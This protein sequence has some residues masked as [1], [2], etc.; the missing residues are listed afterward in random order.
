VGQIPLIIEPDVDEPDFASVMVDA[1]VAGRP[2]RLMLD[3]GAGQTNLDAD[4]YTRGL[5]AVGEDS[6]AGVF[7]TQVIYPVVTVADLAVGPLRLASLDVR[8]GENVKAEHAVSG[9]L[10]LDVL[11]RY[12]CHFRLDAGILDVDPSPGAELENELLMDRR[13]HVFVEVHWPGI[14]GR[15]LWDTGSGPTIVNHAFWIG[16]PELFEQIGVSEGLDASG[17]RAETPLLLIA[18][19][20]IGQRT[21]GRHKAVAVDL[22]HVN[23]TS[24]YPMDLILG[25]PTQRQADWLFDFPARR[26][27]LTR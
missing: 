12:R 25:Y 8:R 21:F 22:S 15:A 6:S 18:E 14:S 19:S 2:Y 20:Q 17:E 3:T 24:D 7:G 5:T 11:G 27:A 26:W 9:V 4:D 10:G 16:H 23:S 13:G 1:T